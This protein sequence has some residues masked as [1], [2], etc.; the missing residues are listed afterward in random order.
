V[1]AQDGHNNS[2]ALLT[3]ASKHPAL[4][5]ADIETIYC[6]APKFSTIPD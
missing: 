4:S 5:K 1:R 2:V 3:E 6:L